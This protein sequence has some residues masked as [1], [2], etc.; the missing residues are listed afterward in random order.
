[1]ARNQKRSNREIKKPKK[2]ALTPPPDSGF[3]RRV[4]MPTLSSLKKKV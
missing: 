2:K 1:M 3:S 4:Q